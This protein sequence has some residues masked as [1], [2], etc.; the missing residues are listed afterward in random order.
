MIL[1]RSFLRTVIVVVIAIPETGPGALDRR[2]GLGR[3]ETGGAFFKHP[4]EE[5]FIIVGIKLRSLD[6]IYYIASK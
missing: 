6:C 1:G 5:I 3:E 4:K 2:S